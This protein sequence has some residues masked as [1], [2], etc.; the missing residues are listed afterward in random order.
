M[1]HSWS[2]EGAGVPAAEAGAPPE[3]GPDP[4][5]EA[6]DFDVED[7]TGRIVRLSRYRTRPVVLWFYSSLRAD[8]SMTEGCGFRDRMSQFDTRGVQVFGVGSDDVAQSAAFAGQLRLNFPLLCDTDHAIAQAYG[9]DRSRMDDPARRVTCV[10][11]PSGRIAHWYTV[12]RVPA[13]EVLKV[14]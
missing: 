1:E 4:G 12:A 14:L 11:D 9:V 3:T 2:N 13:A 8:D 10:I 5:A 6:P 7:H